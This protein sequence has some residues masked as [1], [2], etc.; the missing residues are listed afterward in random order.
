MR[1]PDGLY[2]VWVIYEENGQRNYRTLGVTEEVLRRL[3]ERVGGTPPA[4][5]QVPESQAPESQSAAISPAP[6]VLVPLFLVVLLL[7][8]LISL[9]H[10]GVI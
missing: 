10:R 9:Q 1:K 4:G 7:T 2:V 6:P 5:T 8:W 3:Y